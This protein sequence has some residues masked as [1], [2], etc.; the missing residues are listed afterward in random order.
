MTKREGIPPISMIG[1]LALMIIF[2]WFRYGYGLL[3]SEFKNEFDLSTSMLGVISSLTFV[4]FLVGAL[5]VVLF[6][7][8][9]GS[10]HVIM[11]G[12]MTASTGLLIASLTGSWIIFAAACLLAGFSPGLTW[13]SFSQSVHEHLP[14]NIQKRT[15]AVISTGSTVGLIIIS[16]IYLFLD[17]NWRLVWGGGAVMGYLIYW[18][19]YKEVPFKKE[20]SSVKRIRITDLQPL[21]TKYT[22]P[23]YAA[24]FLFG[25]TESTYWTYSADFVQDNFSIAN[26][27]AIFFLI[28]GVGGLAGLLGGELISRW[29]MRWSFT[30][31]IVLYSLSMSVL[32]LSQGWLLVCFSGLTFGISFMLYAAYLPIWSAKV[33]PKFPAQGFSIC[34]IVLNIGAILGPAVFGWILAYAT[35]SLIFLLLGII[36]LLKLFTLP[37]LR[38]EF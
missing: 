4:T 38:N 11:A 9:F 22:K 33:F 5:T 29:G 21:F 7:S 13:S 32:F 14:E 27:N 3:F 35:Y 2:G 34:I 19:A 28:T 23:F 8:R 17:G 30:M 37:V 24:S 18:W 31:T 15:L 6:V 16:T 1:L 25:F 26:S 10:R 36:G 20:N 12:I